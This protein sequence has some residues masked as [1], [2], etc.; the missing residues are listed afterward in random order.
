MLARLTNFES[1]ISL[2]EG[3]G[4]QFLDFGFGKN[5]KL[6]SEGNFLD[7]ELTKPSGVRTPLAGT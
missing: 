3:T 6:L 4:I 2:I 5:I 7:G 1:Q